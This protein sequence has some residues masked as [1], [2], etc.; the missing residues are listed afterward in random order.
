MTCTRHDVVLIVPTHHARRWIDEFINALS[1]Q[2]VRPARLLVIDSQSRDGTPETFAASGAEVLAIPSAKFDHGGTRQLGFD[3]T[4]PAEIIVY[5]TQDAILA[6]ARALGNLLEAFADPAV[7]IAYGRQLPRRGAKSIEAHARL[8]NY[9]QTSLRKSLPDALMLGT[10][11]PFCSNSFAAYRRSALT[12]IG[13]F[14][15]RTIMGEDQYA[16]GTAIL[17]GWTVAYVA[18]ACVYHSHTY[19]TVQEFRRYFDMGVFHARNRFLIETFGHAGGEG[20]RYVRSEIS[21]LSRHAPWLIPTALLKSAAKLIG[22]KLGLAEKRLPIE[23][24][25]NNH[26]IQT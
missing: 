22:Y 17:A 23:S 4:H 9:G 24:A 25:E 19:S 16:A 10:K 6:D 18:E 13:G 15:T 21:Y 1:C 3:L 12:S 26:E 5:L 20:M 14:P 7:G 8:F 11:A 2:K